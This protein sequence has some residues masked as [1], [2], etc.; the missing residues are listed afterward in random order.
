MKRSAP[1]IGIAVTVAT[2]GL[3]AQ[4]TRVI[5]RVGNYI[6]LENGIRFHVLDDW[7]GPGKWHCSNQHAAISAD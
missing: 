3:P 5:N 7:V 1:D 2:Q 4:R 6:V